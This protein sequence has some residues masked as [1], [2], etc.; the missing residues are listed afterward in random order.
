MLKKIC[1]LIEQFIFKSIVKKYRVENF[2]IIEYWKH[3][4][5]EKQKYILSIKQIQIRTSSRARKMNRIFEQNENFQLNI[6]LILKLK[7][8]RWFDKYL[9]VISKN[10]QTQWINSISNVDVKFR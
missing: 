8:E 10:F 2:K 3:R 6:D 1:D 5:N 9:N 4:R 7:K